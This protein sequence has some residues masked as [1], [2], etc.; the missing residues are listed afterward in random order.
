M[1]ERNES[2]GLSDWRRKLNEVIFGV[3][4]PA[5][6]AF[7]IVL[8][9][10]IIISVVAVMLESVSEIRAGY[11]R[12]LRIIEWGFTILFTVEYTLRLICVQ[13]RMRYAFSFFG[14]VD[15]LA[16]VPTYLGVFIGGAQSLIVIRTLRLLRIFR[17]LK[18]VHFMEDTNVVGRALLNSRRKITAFLGTVV[19]IAL[20]AGTLMYLIEGG[21]VGKNGEPSDFTSI[22]RSMYWAIVT[23]T[24]V[25]FGDI[26]PQTN[27]GQILASALMIAGYSIIAVPT[28]IFSVELAQAVRERPAGRPC[29]ACQTRGHSPQAKFCH[30]CGR[31]LSPEEDKSGGE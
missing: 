26:T 11:G 15:F 14:M 19:V 9:A 29:P 24:T 22:P 28:G 12:L 16:I 18:L 7:D 4:T 31:Q 21:L 1:S 13:R 8:L 20:I 27:L 2:T 3:D 30:M 6:K 23:V 17:I 10:C 25:G 5:G